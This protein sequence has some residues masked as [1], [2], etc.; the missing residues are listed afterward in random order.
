MVK[1]LAKR[2]VLLMP[3]VFIIS[4][5]L[6][7]MFK[8]MPGDPVLLMLPPDLRSQAERDLYYNAYRER[9]GLDK[10][11]PE[12]YVAWVGNISRLEFGTSIQNNRPVREV[13]ARPLRNSIVLNTF[14]IIFAF[15]ISIPV[16]IHSAVKRQS[17]FDS[18]WQVFSLFGLSVPV[19]FIGLIL[20]YVFAIQLRWLPA[21]G[22]PRLIDDGS[23]A[24]FREWLR[25]I[26]L[27]ITTLTIGSL[28]GTIRYVRNAM[29]DIISRDYIRTARSKGLSEKVTIYRHAFR[30]ALI[31]VVTLVAGSLV[32]LFGGSA[33]TESIFAWNGIGRVLIDS[34]NNRDYMVVLTMN[35]F[36]AVLSLSA[37][38]IMDIGYALVDPRVKLD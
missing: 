30:N 9:L 33:I 22:M 8:I 34:L 23:F 16:G 31:P 15:T 29:I 24:Y 6:F 17:F 35:M 19:F 5:M 7:G 18:F 26:V 3:V 12:Q 11:L 32:A 20:I 36:Y 13:I 4:I 2:I 27:P 10:S 37:N 21:N 38:L 14:S 28:A 1:F 25:Y